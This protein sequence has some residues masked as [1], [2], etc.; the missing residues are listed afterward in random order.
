MG[1]KRD[2]RHIIQLRIRT[3]L[4]LLCCLCGV[5]LAGCAGATKPD[6]RSNTRMPSIQK[7][8]DLQGHRGAR[9]LMPENSI[10]GFI[11]ALELGVDTLEMDV[12]INA[13]GHVV[14]SHEPWMLAAICSHPDGRPVAEDEQL[15]L[16]I[17]KMDDVELASYDCGSRQHPNFPRQQTLKTSKPLLSD[18]FIAVQKFREVH[19]LPIVRFNIEIKSRPEFDGIFHPPVDE[20]ARALHQVIKDFELLDRSS[21]Q[22]FD[23]RALEAIHR[24]DPA[25][26]TVWLISNADSLAVNL[27]KLSFKPTI[28]SPDYRLV[29]PELIEQLREH[30]IQLIPWTVNEPDTMRQLMEWGVDGLITDYPDI[31]IGL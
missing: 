27:A 7:P 9:G 29:T 19:Q 2:N 12:V 3:R 21:I 17:Y 25:A 30:D 1:I 26:A 16:N 18:V 13:E 24:I 11:R 14:V 20:F 5:T 4:L 31:A 28:Y 22:S 23:P 10:P 6:I 15:S 8:F